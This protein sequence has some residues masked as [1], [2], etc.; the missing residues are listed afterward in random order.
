VAARA[1]RG[2]SPPPGGG[3]QTQSGSAFNSF[4][5]SYSGNAFLSGTT[6]ASGSADGFVRG[7]NVGGG[8]ILRADVSAGGQS[9]RVKRNLTFKRRTF[10]SKSLLKGVGTNST[11]T[12]K[13]R[14]TSKPKFIRY[15][16]TSIFRLSGGMT[17]T[18]DIKG[19]ARFFRRS[20]QITEIWSATGNSLVFRYRLRHR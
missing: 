3:G 4:A 15:R 8:L 5:G 20:I 19:D 2:G 14:Y 16:E 10:K 7:G 11:V 6:S 13:G 17:Q 18:I 9:L 1:D 12:G